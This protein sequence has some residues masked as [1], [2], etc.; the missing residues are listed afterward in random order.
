MGRVDVLPARERRE[1]ADSD[2]DG[3]VA[4]RKYPSITGQMVSLAIPDVEMALDPG[5]VVERAREI[6]PDRHPEGIRAVPCG[7]EGPP[8]TRVGPV[9]DD[10]VL[11][12]YRA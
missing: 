12:P 9:G 5:L 10:H 3:T 1:Q 6:A 7:S 2:I 4:N 8:E 11:G